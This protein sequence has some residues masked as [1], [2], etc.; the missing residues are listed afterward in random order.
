MKNKERKLK[1]V[2]SLLLIVILSTICILTGCSTADDSRNN[3]DLTVIDVTEDFYVNDFANL[4][5]ETQKAD[6]MAK[7]IN[8]DVEYSGIQVVITTV[9]SFEQTVTNFNG[10]N[11]ELL[12]IEQI[13]YSMYSQYGI[14]KD[15]MG[16]LILFSVGDREV[17]IETGW[18]MQNY[19]TDLLSGEILDDYGMPYFTE[20]NFAEGLISVQAA[21]IEEIQNRVP[22]DWNEAE[23][24][25][26]EKNTSTEENIITVK[27][28]EVLEEE[29]NNNDSNNNTLV[30]FLISIVTGIAGLFVSLW[31]YLKSKFTKQMESE[32]EQN[33]KQILETE[34]RYSE[35]MVEQQV[36]FEKRIAD[37]SNESVRRER[38]KNSEIGNLKRELETANLRIG[39]LNN[40]VG[41][42]QDK[43]LRIQTLHPEFNFDKEVEEMIENEYKDTALGI[44][45]QL[46]EVA[47]TSANKD[48]IAFFADA[49][50]LYEQTIPQVK[51]YVTTDMEKVTALHSDSI[52]LKQEFDRQEQEKHDRKVANHF[53]E[54]LCAMLLNIRQIGNHETYEELSNVRKEYE[55]LSREQREFISDPNKVQIMQKLYQ[56]AKSDNDDFC[57]AKETEKSIESVVSRIYSADEDDV[58]KLKR[59]LREY[60]NLSSRQ[61]EYFSDELLRK[62]KRLLE[63]AEEDE[64][65]QEER[66]RQNRM[67]SSYSSSSYHRPSTSHRSSFGGHGGRPSGGGASRRF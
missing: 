18:K 53:S 65:R 7:A 43:Y 33:Q 37:I 9:E 46:A 44:D 29:N 13:S 40:E 63:D 27:D 55:K 31:A 10:E 66:R 42:L 38:E 24:T 57:K 25:E 58:D 36:A 64:R 54:I 5:N 14:G 11:P 62:L 45:K 1:S 49:I 17:R 4:F 34:T 59:A 48:N 8:M 2:R 39:D 22:T 56:E 51:K 20:D 26:V 50:S 32:K 30:G 6:L 23:T 35:K 28:S 67:S 47:L 41:I 3:Y 52:A 60:K 12:T 61:K 15:S 21:V 19:F 16:I